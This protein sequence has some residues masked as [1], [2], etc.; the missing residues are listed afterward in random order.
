MG[1]GGY[2]FGYKTITQWEE[3]G[4]YYQAGPPSIFFGSDDLVDVK[5]REARI[6]GI[7]RS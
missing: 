6:C 5:P 2:T 4:Q 3:S 1:P 7:W